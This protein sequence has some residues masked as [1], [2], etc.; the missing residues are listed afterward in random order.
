MANTRVALLR[1]VKVGPLYTPGVLSGFKAQ[2]NP[3]EWERFQEGLISRPW[4]LCRFPMVKGKHDLRRVILPAPQ[5]HAAKPLFGPTVAVEKEFVG[6]YYLDYRELGVRRKQTVLGALEDPRITGENLAYSDIQRAIQKIE[7][8][9]QGHKLNGTKVA[10]ASVPTGKQRNGATVNQSLDTYMEGFTAKH[11]REA[12]WTC[13]R[14]FAAWL[15]GK[16]PGQ[17]LEEG[18]LKKTLVGEITAGDLQAYYKYMAEQAPNPKRGGLGLSATTRGAKLNNLY[19]W[20]RGAG[21]KD[22]LPKMVE[23]D[24]LKVVVV[25]KEKPDT[26]PYTDE[27]LRRIFNF[28]RNQDETELLTLFH[29]T[30]MR[31]GEVAHAHFTDLI[32]SKSG[33]GGFLEVKEK[34]EFDWKPKSKNSYRKAPIPVDVW[35]ML[36]KRRARLKGEKTGLIFPTGQKRPGNRMLRTLKEI[37]EL[38]RLDCAGL[39][40]SLCAGCKAGRECR[41]IYLHKFRHS[42]ITEMLRAGHTPKDLAAW[43]GDDVATIMR[44][45]AHAMEDEQGLAALNAKVAAKN[46]TAVDNLTIAELEALLAARKGQ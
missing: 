35:E 1:Q 18:F 44:V 19:P 28:C 5:T 27:A 3:T 25:A 13:L 14:D 7:H 20:L 11:T 33:S 24:E 4:R 15:E 22:L 45:Y 42:Y 37:G 17:I 39:G 26:S 2:C 16:A 38:A 6:P 30:G 46:S 41:Q 31:S 40:Q 29:R 8:K 23:K 21:R 43:V 34:P 9:L 32:P 36:R 10:P 12:Y